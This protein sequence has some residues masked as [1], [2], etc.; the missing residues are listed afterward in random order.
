MKN[1]NKRRKRTRAEE[2]ERQDRCK[3]KSFI[4]PEDWLSGL[5]Q[6][7]EKWEDEAKREQAR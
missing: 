1:G 5:K 4:P 7:A 3:A 6:E 2:R